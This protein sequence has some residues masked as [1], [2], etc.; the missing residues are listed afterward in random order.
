MA[1]PGTIQEFL[2]AEG[3]NRPLAQLDLDKAWHAIHYLLTGSNWGGE[4]P[5]GMAVLGGMELGE[6]IGYG[7]VRFLTP[8]EVQAVAVLLDTLSQQTLQERYVPSALEA[9][10]IYPAGIWEEEGQ[11][12]FEWLMPWFFQLVAFYK[13]AGKNGNA[14]LLFLN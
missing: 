9:V 11:Q 3:E 7:P 2:N 10:G 5:L 14:M 12:A 1:E 13:A 4:Y 6:D 8:E